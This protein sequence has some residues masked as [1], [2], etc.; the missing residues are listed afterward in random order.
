M[1]QINYTDTIHVLSQ[2]ELECY[3]NSNRNI[4]AQICSGIAEY[5]DSLGWFDPLEWG[6]DAACSALT[7]LA[8]EIQNKAQVF[9]V[10]GV[11]GSNNAARSVI[12][13]LAA[14]SKVQ[15]YYAGNTLSPYEIQKL[16]SHVKDTSFYIN[17]IAKNFE[18]LEPGSAFRVLRKILYEKYGEDAA[19]RIIC[20]GTP[21][22]HLENL[23]TKHGWR[24]L[25]FPSDIGGRY[26]SVS[27]VGLLPMAV[28]GIDITSLVRG[29][30]DMQERLVAA[31]AVENYAYKYACIRNLLYNKGYKIELLSFF[32]PRFK[33]FSKWWIQ[34]FAESEGKEG[35]GLFP[36]AAEYSEEL[37]AVGQFVQDG[38]HMLFE[39]FLDVLSQDASWMAAGDKVD[40]RFGYL[41][42][43]DFWDINKK[44]FEATLKA[45]SH[46][47]PCCTISI[48]AINP[49]TFGELFYC[50][51]F[52]CYI[53]A[54]LLGVNPFD[55]PGVEAYKQYMFKALGKTQ[56]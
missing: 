43:F 49:Y 17:V 6:N 12:H 35:K 9:V 42:R 30:K 39:T 27:N 53:S 25:A 20:T 8:S 37:H 33:Y 41:D 10:V 36:C 11:G 23:C 31:D 3:M 28:A 26:S 2:A 14:D 55:Q 4:L 44:A 18:T 21:N 7:S 13:A 34:L 50:F 29:A 32:E 46:I 1:L 48:D 40:D 52:A 54:L 16:V 56:K 51:E 24:F 19:E 38:S 15:I 22:S 47:L 45:H 5:K